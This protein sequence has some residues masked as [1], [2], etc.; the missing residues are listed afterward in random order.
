[1]AVTLPTHAK[2]KAT[3]HICRSVLVF[4]SDW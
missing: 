3:L 4:H 2:A 1:L